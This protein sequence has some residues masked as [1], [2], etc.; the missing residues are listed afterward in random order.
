[1][2]INKNLEDSSEKMAAHF[3]ENNNQSNVIERGEGVEDSSK[4]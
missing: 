3:T 1:M 2:E 4:I